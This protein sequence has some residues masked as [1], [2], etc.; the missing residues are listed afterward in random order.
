M[1]LDWALLT[2]AFTL[3]IASVIKA[4]VVIQQL[5]EYRYIAE[6]CVAKILNNMREG[7]KIDIPGVEILVLKANPGEKPEENI[8]GKVDKVLAKSSGSIILQDGT[9][10]YIAVKTKGKC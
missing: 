7:K 9:L 10:V 5:P 1:R 2:I 3:L 6:E 4:Y 8:L